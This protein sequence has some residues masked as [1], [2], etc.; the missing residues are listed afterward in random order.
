MEK[1]ELVE[2]RNDL[3][4][5]V[6]CRWREGTRY[7]IRCAIVAR[8]FFILFRRRFGLCIFEGKTNSHGLLVPLDKRSLI[9][10]N[11][12]LAYNGIE[13]SAICA[14]SDVENELLGRAEL[15]DCRDKLFF[16]FFLIVKRFFDFFMFMHENY[17][18]RFT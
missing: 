2:G 17:R 9:E 8:Y 3:E 14:T 12:M 15:L 16:F 11:E 13:F 18:I 7:G 1:R 4:K 5:C 10:S 6:H